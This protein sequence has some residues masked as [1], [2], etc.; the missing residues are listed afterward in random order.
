MPTQRTTEITLTRK[1]LK[2]LALAWEGC[3]IA[4]LNSNFEACDSF[5][6]TIDRIMYCAA[7]HDPDFK[8]LWSQV[9]ID[10]SEYNNIEDYV[11]YLLDCLYVKLIVVV[12]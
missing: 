5:R 10:W 2:M 4:T 7:Y 11:R 1:E 9:V 6:D 3:C 8:E 12:E